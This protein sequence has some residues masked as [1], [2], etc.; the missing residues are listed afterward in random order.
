MRKV[1]P[2][3][4]RLAL[5]ASLL[6][7][8]RSVLAKAG[9]MHLT[10]ANFLMWHGL[11]SMPVLWLI[12]R[13][14]NV[15]LRPNVSHWR[16]Y[17]ARIGFGLANLI[18]LFTA[19]TYLPTSVATTLSFTAPIFAALLA[20]A[21]LQEKTTLP[22]F[23]GIV[24]GFI[25]ISFAA[26][27]HI[28]H[29]NRLFM[30]VGL[31]AGFSSALMQIYARQLARVGEPGLRTVFW[32]NGA[33]ASVGLIWSVI[34]GIEHL[35]LVELVLAFNIALFGV[36]GQVTTMSAYKRGPADIVNGLSYLVLPVSAGLAYVF[37]REMTGALALMGMAITIAACSFL[38][39]T[40]QRQLRQAHDTKLELTADDLREERAQ[41]QQ[42]AGANGEP[43]FVPEP[44]A[45]ELDAEQHARPLQHAVEK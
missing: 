11:L 32:L 12:S 15:S 19:L 41:L 28:T 6:F 39:R 16:L 42:G 17:S 20:P 22:I 34:Q 9:G 14:N 8:G 13:A 30:A 26:A 2:H 1:L 24:V 23:G 5:L 40:E 31:A 43:L 45:A 4:A 36:L 10:S 44:T 21:L 3:F 27:P 33:A 38:L 29:A 37:L 18:F 7:A 25:G 35:T